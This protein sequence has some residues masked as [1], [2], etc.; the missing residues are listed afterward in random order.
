MW[1]EIQS[2]QGLDAGSGIELSDGTKPIDPK[3]D[4][5]KK[6]LDKVKGQCALVSF[7][8]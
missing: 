5:A 7:F 3:A 2:M 6:F 4:R 8:R 1:L